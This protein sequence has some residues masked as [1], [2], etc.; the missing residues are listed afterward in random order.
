MRSGT[1][2]PSPAGNWSYA[3]SAA[4]FP[5]HGSYTIRVKATDNAT[6]AETPSSRTFTYSSTAPAGSLTAPAEGAVIFGASVTVSSDSADGGSGVA[7]A[8]FERRPAGG[9]SWTTIGT[10]A[11]APYSASWDTTSVSD[12]DYDLRVTTDDDAGN[13]FSSATRTVTIDNTD[14]ASATLDAFRARSGIARR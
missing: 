5:A 2:P 3:F 9:G 12:G 11:S 6:N 1:R 10:D 8:T 14:P 4:S 7:L 13:S